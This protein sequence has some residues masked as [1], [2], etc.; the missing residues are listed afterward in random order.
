MLKKNKIVLFTFLILFGILKITV[1]QKFKN[2]Q[3]LTGHPGKIEVITYSPDGKYLI[4]SDSKGVIIFWDILNQKQIQKIQAHDSKISNISFNKR[5]N[6]MLT[7]T[8]NGDLKIWDWRKYKELNSTSFSYPGRITFAYFD[9]LDNNVYFDFNQ[10]IY[11]IS[12][13]FKDAAK[14]LYK[15]KNY[16]TCGAF[17]PDGKHLVF[18]DELSIVFYNLETKKITKKMGYCSSFVNEITFYSYYEFVTWCQDGTINYW[19]YNTQGQVSTKPIKSFKAGDYDN[20]SRIT[21]SKNKKYFITG[22]YGSTARVWDSNGNRVIADLIGHT[23]TVRGFAF[24]PDD[25]YLITAS[26]DKTIKIWEVTQEKKEVENKT[27]V[28]KK[29]NL[30]TVKIIVKKEP[31][32]KLINTHPL[33]LKLQNRTIKPKK[34]FE[35]YQEN[36]ELF[37][38][39][40]ETVDGDVISINVN[41]KW[42]LEKYKLVKEQKSVKIKLDKNEVDN[43]VIFYAENLGNISPNTSAIKF[44]DGKKDQFFVMESDFSTNGTI[45]FVFK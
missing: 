44:F 40:N 23:D 30:D 2:I 24:S 25:K 15:C 28:T 26:F 38:W 32:K 37:I 43:Y 19:N 27:K 8:E 10:G 16:S 45:K 4:S 7:A 31:E 13:D 17:S 21:Y 35:I 9:A 33:P 34:T 42:V 39:D 6:L 1:A 11:C 20:Y 3:T 14:L 18:G 41:G 12:T 5:G 29:N 36:I 22:S